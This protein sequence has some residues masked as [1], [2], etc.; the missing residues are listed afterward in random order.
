MEKVTIK[1]VAKHA[2]VS[3][4]TVSRVINNNY[5]VSPEVTKTV[6]HSI[7]ELQYVPNLIARSLK[8]DATFSLG[9]LVSDITNNYFIE[10]AKA[11]EDI[12]NNEGYSLI[13]C[14]TENKRKRELAYLELLT[15]KKI[16]GLVLNTTGE[17]DD[18][19]VGLSKKIPVVAVNRKIRDVCF[20]GDLVDSNSVQG[21]YELTTHLLDLGHR[22][23]FVLNG[24]LNVS[25]GRERFTGFQKAM[26]EVG[27][28]AGDGYPYRYDG[29]FTL[30]AG[31]QG[32]AA[33]ARMS[34]RPTAMIVMN[35]MMTVGAL[36]YVMNNG[37]SVPEELSIVSYERIENIELFSV[38]PTIAASDPSLMGGKVAELMLE[39]IQNNGLNNR[40][41][42]FQPRLIVGNG[43]RRI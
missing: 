22:K 31:Y 2:G 11:V 34:D 4:A 40:E 18:Y 35:N 10:M 42:V 1:D 37:V 36:K 14:S 28:D 39:R 43:E 17:N 19:V 23:I 20:R 33:W 3:V 16:D 9:F 5:Y 15:S 13:V 29:D 24:S 32:A 21:A 7:G 12:V 26:H 8:K 38:R 27:I 41:I 25:T 6:Q 30:E